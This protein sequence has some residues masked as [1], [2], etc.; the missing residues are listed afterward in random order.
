MQILENLKNRLKNIEDLLKK[1]F[2][3]LRISRATPALVENILVDYY[4]VKTP[5]KQL[6]SISAP[7][8]RLLTI[9]PW[10]KN[11]L[12]SIEK[13]ILSSNLGLNPIADKNLIR[14]NIPSLTEERRDSLVKIIWSSLKK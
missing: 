2:S 6:A 7:E 9:E 3:A 10:D 1:E 13:A 12:N 4:G 8:P 5:L 11:A 14:I